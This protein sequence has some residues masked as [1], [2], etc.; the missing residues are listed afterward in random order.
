[1]VYVPVLDAG[2][3]DEL[4]IVV[5]HSLEAP[6]V[7]DHLFPSVTSRSDE[8]HH[9]GVAVSH[10]QLVSPDPNLLVRLVEIICGI[11]YVQEVLAHFIL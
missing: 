10:R 6:I 7:V 1:M 11:V 3:V 2:D 4:H 9:E 5:H 8:G